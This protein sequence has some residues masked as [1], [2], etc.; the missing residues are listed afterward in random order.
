MALSNELNGHKQRTDEVTDIIDRMPSHFGIYVTSLIVF[1][2]GLLL[3]FGWRIKYPDLVKGE[4]SLSAR[5]APVNLVANSSGKI[6]IL[7]LEK[8]REVHAGEYL[9]V[10]KNPAVT[11][12][13]ELVDSLLIAFDILKVRYFTNR[14]IFPQNVSLGELSTK[15]YTFLASLYEYID[16]YRTDP[17]GK[18]EE[19]TKVLLKNQEQLLTVEN[20]EVSIL[21]RKYNLAERDF[22]RDSNLY[23]QNVIDPSDIDKSDLSK[24]AY[25][26]DMKSA[27]KDVLTDKYQIDDASNKLEQLSVQRIDKERQLLVALLGSYSDLKENIRLWEKQ[28]VLV[29]PFDGKMEFLDFLKNDD[30]VNSG[31]EIF[32]IIPSEQGIYGQVLLPEAG[33]G[34]VR[35][36]QEVIAKLNN[37]PFEEFGTMRGKVHSISL[38]T[39]QQVDAGTQNKIE[40]FLVTVELPDGLTTNYGKPL[41]FYFGAKGTAEIITNDKRLY[42]RL[43]DNLRYN[44]KK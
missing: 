13:V 10:I 41:N 17:I 26:Q 40:V 23:I 43:F 24:I 5:Q 32:S 39:N 19:I 12:D 30:F 42:Q 6:E 33:A 20:D 11:S 22:K 18:Q 38:V 25:E 3:F 16:Y 27:S 44:L 36:G 31:K 34:K 35:V 37:S 8:E 4:I 7:H 28:Y 15:Y 14:G 29:A 1:I 2:S 21:E 9:A